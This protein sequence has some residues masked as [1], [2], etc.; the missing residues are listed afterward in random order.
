MLFE[1]FFKILDCDPHM[2]GITNLNG[3]ANTIALPDAKATVQY[4][5]IL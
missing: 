4:N 3:Y 1:E 5:F 2:D